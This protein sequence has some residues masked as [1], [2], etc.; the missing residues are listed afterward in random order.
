VLASGCASRHLVRLGGGNLKALLVLLMLAVSSLATLGL[1][2]GLVLGVWVIRNPEG[3][4]ARVW[5][6]G[7]GIGALV[8]E[9]WWLSG[10]HGHVLEHPVTLQQTFLANHSHRM[11]ALSRVSPIGYALD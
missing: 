5:V 7:P 11:E 6:R 2:M 3:R 8:V 9:M 10:R 4:A 1:V